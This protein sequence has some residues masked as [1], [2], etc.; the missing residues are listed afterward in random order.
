[1]AF[2]LIIE[3]CHILL[4]KQNKKI[5]RRVYPQHCGWAVKAK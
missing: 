1:M 4:K 3:T 5:I 2:G